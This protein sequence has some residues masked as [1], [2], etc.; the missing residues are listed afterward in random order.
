[1]KKFVLAY[2]GSAAGMLALDVIWLSTMA[3]R[4][5]RPQLGA[6]LADDFRLGPAIAFYVLYIFGIVYFVVLRALNGSDWRKAALDG[7]LLG[8]VAY[9]AYDLTNQATLNHWPLL[10]TS[11]DLVW[12]AFLT[13]FSAVTGFQTARR[14]CA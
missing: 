12:G 11:L 5:Y 10:V 4:V 6:L 9:G 14:F 8:L 7:A 3:E 2:L 1:M 13:A